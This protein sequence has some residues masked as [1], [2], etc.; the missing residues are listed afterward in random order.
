MRAP[1]IDGYDD[2]VVI[3]RGASSTVYRAHQAAHDRDVAIKVLAIDISDR[4]ARRRFDR[5]RSVNGRL[6]AHPNV[7]TVLE[8][9]LVD[10]RQPYLAMELFEH[11][12]LADRLHRR[13]A[14]EV[15]ETLRHGIRICGALETAHRLGVLHRDIKPHN[16]LLSRYGEPALA[17][18]GIASLLENERAMT[19]ALTPSHAAPELLEG[20]E[21]TPQS[22]VYSL[23]SSLFMLLAGTPP[24]AGPDDEGVLAQLLRITTG[25]VP[26]LRR[27]DVPEHLEAVLRSALAKRGADRP[28]SAL[29]FGRVLQEI[30][31]ELGVP[32][33]ALP[34]DDD[35]AGDV[36]GSVPSAP[37]STDDST[38]VEMV[39][40]PDVAES[41]RPMAPP[42]TDDETIDVPAGVAL[43]GRAAAVRR[44]DDGAFADDPIDVA[45]VSS[46]TVVGRGAS[47][48]RI[49]SEPETE[50]RW[51]IVVWSIIAVVAGVVAIFGV[52]A[53][54]RDDGTD[55]VGDDGVAGEAAPAAGQ[56]TD[57]E[58]SLGPAPTADE[59]RALAPID[60]A[61]QPID[62]G[63]LVTWDDRADGAYQ[64][65]VVARLLDGTDVAVDEP[66]SPGAETATLDVG[67]DRVECIT[68][69]AIL[70]RVDGELV[71]AESA[72]FCF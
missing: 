10:G 69:M 54:V 31:T 64:F 70:G 38:D 62:T 39:R 15:A 34:L 1:R 72:P 14:F 7:V 37:P 58:A 41:G 23:G 68:V 61:A 35:I 21:P 50:R 8:S 27:P 26:P 30:Q 56:P 65:V 43:G 47:V 19:A 51:P 32:V 29:E 45:E 53:L 63:V 67:A 71:R 55:A 9:G 12:S 33:T 59:V 60:V 3:G 36:A 52:A 20:D 2:L 28:S 44:V 57:G 18:F 46:P 48:R 40:P 42:T 11:G 25:E 66:T 4:R 16:I 6:S 24:F 17:D 22:D 5:E 49:R 13:G